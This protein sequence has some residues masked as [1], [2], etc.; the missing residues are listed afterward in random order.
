MRWTLFGVG[1]GIASLACTF[2][3][4]LAVI[5]QAQATTGLA[6]QTAVFAAY[7]AGSLALLLPLRP[8]WPHWQAPRQPAPPARSAARSQ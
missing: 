3:V 4:L 2:A 8:V 1:Y 7:T 6:G 5:V